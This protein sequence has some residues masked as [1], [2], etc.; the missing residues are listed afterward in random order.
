MGE[1]WIDVESRRMEHGD[2]PALQMRF[3]DD[4]WHT[5]F[6][7]PKGWQVV[8]GPIGMDLGTFDS[9]RAARRCAKDNARTRAL[10]G[11]KSARREIDRAS[12]VLGALAMHEVP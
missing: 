4:W 12:V 8:L 5:I 1:L 3:H 6:E 2:E 7:T 10:N 11:L 9:E